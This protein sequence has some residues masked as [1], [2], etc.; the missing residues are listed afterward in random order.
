MVLKDQTDGRLVC[1]S[2]GDYYHPHLTQESNG[3]QNCI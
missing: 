1:G 2:P 3:Q